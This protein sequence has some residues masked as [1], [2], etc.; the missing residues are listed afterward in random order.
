[1]APGDRRRAIVD[2]VLPLLERH[3]TTVTTRQIAEAAGIAEGTVFRAFED[4]CSLFAAVAEAA[5][6]PPGWREELARV[7]SA[8]DDL[9][10]KV[11]VTAEGMATRMRQVMLAMMALRGAMVAEGGR[12]PVPGRPPEFLRDSGRELHEAVTALVFEPHRDELRLAPADA[13]RAMRSLVMGSWHPGFSTRTGCVRIRSPT[14]SST[15]SGG[16]D[17]LAAA[18]HRAR[19]VPRCHHARGRRSSSSARWPR[20]SCPRSTPTSSTTA[21]PTATPPHRARS[22]G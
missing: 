19:A 21:S 16:A 6:R 4:K 5:A 11:L 9:R 17:A 14:S 13:A 12:G 22:V 10:G 2:A 1:M 18:A 15:A 3:G 7:V 8:H 20:C